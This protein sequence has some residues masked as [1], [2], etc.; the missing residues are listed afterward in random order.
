[1]AKDAG[2]NS[3][4]CI[5]LEAVTGDG[6]NHVDPQWWLS[7]DVFVVGSPSGRVALGP[8]TIKVRTHRKNNCQL[9]SETNNINVQV[10]ACIPGPVINPV[11]DGVQARLLGTQ[12]LL[13]AAGG[14]VEAS[15]T[16]NATNNASQPEG[17]GHKCLIARSYPDDLT[18]DGGSLVHL[19]EDQHY[20][21]HNIC[22]IECGAPGAARVPG[23]CALDVATANANLEV[24]EN[25]VLQLV[26][27]LRPSKTM[28]ATLMPRLNQIPS[29][30]R[31]ATA[32]P[33]TFDLQ[34]PDF[35]G[36]PV[37]RGRRGCWG[38]LWGRRAEP[39]YAA[40]IKLAPA[41]VTHFSVRA[42][43]AKSSFGDAHIFHLTQVGAD[44]RVQG[45][46][47]VVMITA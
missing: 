12:A 20:G 45:G 24:A 2:L 43:L 36:A 13:L 22:I 16:L 7:P 25:V 3:D 27:D 11:P 17:F 35:P 28:L 39:T 8:N 44:G 23:P 32:E 19:P 5:Y 14:T 21:Q 37:H 1:M 38:L 29:F 15:F 47:T 4:S 18:P 9:G 34:L 46:V 41:Q 26:A 33:R 6:G 42:D 30:K 40:S 10:F 31:I